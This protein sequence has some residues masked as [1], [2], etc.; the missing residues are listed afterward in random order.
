MFFTQK[1]I[2]WLNKLGAEDWRGE[3]SCVI[4]WRDICTSIFIEA[5]HEELKIEISTPWNLIVTEFG[6][7]LELTFNNAII[8]Y[9]NKVKVANMVAERLDTLVKKSDGILQ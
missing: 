7:N 1:Q 8:C 6:K 3:S 5:L 4:H 9:K 2:A